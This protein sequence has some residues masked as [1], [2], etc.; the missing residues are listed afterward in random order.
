M[1]GLLF[2][3]VLLF[4]APFL[5]T[6]LKLVDHTG[7]VRTMSENADISY[8]ESF[9]ETINSDRGYYHSALIRF[10]TEGNKPRYYDRNLIQLRLDLSLFTARYNDGKDIPLTDDMLAALEE[11]VAYIESKE[12]CVIIRFAYDPWFDGVNPQEPSLEMIL[13]HQ[14]QIG[15]V[16]SRHKNAILC[17]ETGLLGPWGELHT[18]PM[19]TVENL[20]AT[21]EQWLDVLPESVCVT[22]RTPWAYSKWRNIDLA[23]ISS[24]ITVP[25]EKAYRVGIYNDG[26]LGTWSDWGT[27]HNRQEE[28]KWLSNQAKHT[29]YGG[30]MAVI[31]EIKEGQ[32]YSSFVENEAFL[33]HTTY[34]NYD[35]NPVAVK[36]LQNEIYN[37]KDEYYHGQ[38]GFTYVNN[39]LGYRLILRSSKLTTETTHDEPFIIRASIENVGFGNIIKPKKL[40]LVFEGKMNT[41]CIPVTDREIK[42]DEYAINVNP[43]NW[44]SQTTTHVRIRMH[45]P[46]G[47]ISGDY[48][49]YLKIAYDPADV[50]EGFGDYPVQL[51]NK[52]EK[53]WNSILGANYIGK[54]RVIDKR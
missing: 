29:P 32:T 1:K 36:N 46:E 54:M 38:S 14:K 26:Y 7:E 44:E 9:D 50:D 22:T 45:V 49:V 18:T 40:F 25:E 6:G 24:D 2:G 13:Y 43:I 30:E 52:D 20:N 34:I 16:L 51:A 28:V 11:T 31:Q 33:T 37:S 8:E 17:M 15:E 47:M 42:A 3:F 48:K 12:H 23:T 19:V 10:A 4:A 35:F 21:L 39:H 5:D 41:Y 27:F 53:I